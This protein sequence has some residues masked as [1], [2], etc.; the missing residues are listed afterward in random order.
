VSKLVK[1]LSKAVEARPHRPVYRMHRYFARRPYSVFSEL[2]SHYTSP[3]DVILDPFCGGG[4]TVVEGVLQ[5][6]RVVGYDLNPLAIF[7]CKM[8]LLEFDAREFAAG[9]ERVH[10]RFASVNDN[11]FRTE[12]RKCKASA[13][14]HWFEYSAFVD[15]C[16]CGL[17]FCVAASSKCGVGTWTCPHCDKSNRISVT[18][19]T[20]FEIVNVSYE[21]RD[22]G[23]SEMCVASEA[24]K[25]WERKIRERLA[26]EERE[27]LRIPSEEIPDCNMQRESA[28]HKKGIRQFRQLFTDRH[29]LAIALLRQEILEENEAVQDWLLLAFSSTLRYANRMVTRNPAWRGDQPLEW[30]KPGFWMPPVHLEANLLEQFERRCGAVIRGKADYES[31]MAGLFRAKRCASAREVLN[32]QGCAFYV[33]AQSATKMAIQ[34]GSIDAI[35]TDPPYGSY[36]H[37][38]DLCNFWTIWFPKRDGLGAIIDDTEEAV[39]ARKKFP[40]AKDARRYQQLLE[41]CFTECARVLKPDGYMVL[42]FHNREPRAWAALLVAATK[43]GF[44]LVPDGV[45]FQDGIK[46]YKHTAQSRR[47]GS[48]IGDFILSFKKRAIGV[49]LSKPA[50]P[51]HETPENLFISA[52][53]RILKRFGPLAPNDLMARLYSEVQ[54]H[55]VRRIQAAIGNGEDM[56]EE[57]LRDFDSIQLF[58][59]HRRQLLEQHFEYASGKWHMKTV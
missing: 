13:T 1:P 18:A 6:R 35:I 53:N 26:Q 54:P 47:D 20:A 15:C 14:A 8:E 56:T 45:L 30:A 21:C 12:C 44:E 41:T 57:L 25:A 59:S 9:R 11:I 5:G 4:V 58:D 32:E 24:D 51:H 31:K 17:R 34:K 33:N 46:V 7:I 50:A 23:C 52:I 48:V 29:L 36:V 16:G 39:I 55:L 19:S 42:T 37:Y 40:G 22:C 38:A 28:L 3:T 10:R 2:I 27:G 43:A 49:R